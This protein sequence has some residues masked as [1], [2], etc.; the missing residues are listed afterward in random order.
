MTIILP[1]TVVI[2]RMTVIGFPYCHRSIMTTKTVIGILA[3]MLG[4]SL[5]FTVMIVCWYSVAPS[6]VLWCH[7]WSICCVCLTNICNIIIVA[8][9]FLYYKIYESNR[10]AK[11]N[12]QLENKDEAKKFKML[13]CMQTKPIITLL[14][15]G[16]ID[17]IG[18][19][20]ISFVYTT[21]KF[22]KNLTRVSI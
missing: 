10:K 13:L 7:C 2:E 8:N 22:Q 12:E 1:V 15:I 21:I 9:S 11:E 3:A 17:V 16:G 20:L 19:V 14:L 6:I 18:N 5:T 4:I